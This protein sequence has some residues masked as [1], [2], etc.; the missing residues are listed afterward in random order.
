MNRLTAGAFSSWSGGELH[1]QPHHALG[2]PSIDTRTLQQD[3]C[4]FALVGPNF[5]G[6]DFV[7]DALSAGARTLVV[8]RKYGGTARERASGFEVNVIEVDCTEVALQRLG[9][10]FR[11]QFKGTVCGITGSSGKTTTKEMMR[12]ALSVHGG[13]VATRGNLNNHLGVPLSLAQLHEDADFGIFEMGMN[14]PNE[15]RTLSAWVRPKIGVITS[16]G[17]AHLEGVGSLEGVA[18]AKGELFETLGAQGFAVFPDD[19][20]YAD[21]L[22]S[23]AGKRLR[24][25]VYAIRPFV[26]F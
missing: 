9:I 1:G 6:H 5:N 18:K 15:I 24:G 13:V 3:D 7:S 8:D 16:I 26:E 25:W 22:M 12:T 10:W 20:P 14:A 23:I 4:F 21:Y 17:E 19:V 11:D 2:R